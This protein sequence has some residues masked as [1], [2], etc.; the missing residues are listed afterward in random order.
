VG[1]SKTVPVNLADLYDATAN[2][3]KRRQWF[4]QG[5]FE[6]SSQTRDKYLRGSWRKTARLEIGFFGKRD[7]KAQ[8]ALAVSKLASKVDV[9]RERKAWKAGLARLQAMIE[10]DPSR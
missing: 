4:P 1:V 7:G 6:L 3:A 10:A 9:E 8:I 2:A 5:A